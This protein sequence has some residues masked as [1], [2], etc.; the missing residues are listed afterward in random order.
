[1]PVRDY[2]R[3]LVRSLE[4]RASVEALHLPIHAERQDF[5]DAECCRTFPTETFPAALLLK[6]E[7]VERGV[8]SGQS[9]IAVVNRGGGGTR[10]TYAEARFDLLYGFR[11]KERNVDLLSP[12]EMLRHWSMT[13]VQ[14][15]LD[16]G[17][18]V[19]LCL[20][21]GGATVRC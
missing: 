1:M 4:M 17:W 11:G 10:R 19:G 14:P 20:D 13:R 9:I 15:P 5:L 18:R 12:F 16:R 8:A 7:E 3:R 2:S 21:G 6:R